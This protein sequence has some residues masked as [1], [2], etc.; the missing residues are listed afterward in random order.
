MLGG[1]EDALV[2]KLLDRYYDGD[3]NKVP[4]I[5]Y[6]GASPVKI[7]PNVAKIYG[8]E[9]TTREDTVTYRIGSSVPPTEEWLETLAGSQV[10]WLRAFLRSTNVVQGSGY[11]ANPLKRLFAPRAHQTVSVSYDSNVPIAI[12][13]RGAARSYGTHKPDFET[14]SVKYDA[15]SRYIAVTIY[16]DRRD[17]SVPLNFAF[18]Y[19]PDQGFSP[20]HEVVEG[21]NQ[22]IK[23]FY[24]KL[25]FGE[26]EVLPE[27]HI[28]DK[29]IGPEVTIDAATVERFCSVIGNQGESF[30]TARTAEVEAPMDFAIVTGW[31]VSLQCSSS[32]N[33]LTGSV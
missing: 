29:F 8:V 3:E 16:E 6:I 26:G 23:E 19:R 5:D 15:T 30:K 11:I 10:T 7:N 12:S 22:R 25:W 28:R 17:I 1:I 32:V 9:I 31:Q 20:I 27:I 4:V 13:V 18:I 21:R 14:I 2:K 24:W 33:V